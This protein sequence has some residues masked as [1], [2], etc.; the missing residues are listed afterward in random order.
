MAGH[1]TVRD[2]EHTDHFWVNPFGMSFKQIKVSDLILVNHEGQVV[3][4]RHHVNRAAFAIHSMVHQARPDVVAAAHSPLGTRQGA[5]VA[6]HSSWNRSPRTPAPSTR[7][8]PC[9]TTTQVS[10]W[11][12]RRG[13][14][15]PRLWAPT[16]R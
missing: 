4:G 11:R 14:A 2:P 9:S 16:R 6:R 8:T 13:A 7:T 10:S 12:P 1:I 15:S 5:V 3:D